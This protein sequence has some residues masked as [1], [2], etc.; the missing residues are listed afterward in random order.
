[1][2][3]KRSQKRGRVADADDTE[4]RLSFGSVV[5]EKPQTSTQQP[6]SVPG[7]LVIVGTYSSVVAG[8]VLSN[9]AKTRALPDGT[10]VPLARRLMLKFST[11]QHVGPV[12]CIALTDKYMATAANG[13]EKIF[14]YTVK[15]KY[16]SLSELGSLNPASEVRCMCFPLATKVASLDEDQKPAEGGAI[17]PAVKATQQPSR[18]KY[19]LCGCADGTIG[20]YNTRTWECEVVVPVHGSFNLEKQMKSHALLMKQALNGKNQKAA[21][22][23]AEQIQLDT[24]DKQDGCGIAAMVTW[25]S[26]TGNTLVITAGVSDRRIAVIDMST[27]TVISKVKLPSVKIDT[28]SQRQQHFERSTWNAIAIAIA[29]RDAKAPE[30][31]CFAVLT[32]FDVWIFKLATLKVIGRFST[33]PDPK[34]LPEGT[35]PIPDPNKELTSIVFLS[36]T[37]AVV[38]TE[39]GALH[40]VYL[41]RLTQF[42]EKGGKAQAE[43]GDSNAAGSAGGD[44]S[45]Y[46]VQ[47]LHGHLANCVVDTSAEVDEK[48]AARVQSL[49]TPNGHVKRLKSLSFMEEARK[50]V[51]GEKQKSAPT[52]MLVTADSSGVV[53]A[54]AVADTSAGSASL[55][56]LAMAQCEGRITTIDAALR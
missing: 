22:S 45:E 6:T 40:V 23:A 10:V 27:A 43:S 2:S 47:F 54:W 34:T 28:T 50:P 35:V 29:P 55:T 51:G 21:E 7:A 52:R 24:L 39:G 20:V 33:R 37:T 15:D 1:M 53:A 41:P 49:F 14:L 8:L 38:G 17:Q 18:S 36:A 48:H 30:E 19:L 25:T 26:P 32:L 9:K 56:Q 42:K 4:R 46:E 13:D 3:E 11:K 12:N 31:Q 5:D 16:T 44:R